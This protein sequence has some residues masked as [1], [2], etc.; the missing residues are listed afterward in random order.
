MKKTDL[1]ND[2]FRMSHSG[3]L[4]NK[5]DLLTLRKEV[6]SFRRPGK[7]GGE[8]RDEIYHACNWPGGDAIGLEEKAV[9][10]DE[11]AQVIF[12]DTLLGILTHCHPF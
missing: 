9:P 5:F 10:T 6:T 12:W 3:A 8:E 2:S 4:Y 7:G 1:L 11:L